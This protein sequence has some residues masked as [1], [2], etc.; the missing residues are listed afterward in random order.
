MQVDRVLVSI[1]RCDV[2]PCIHD[3]I[4]NRTNSIEDPRCITTGVEHLNVST[5]VVIRLK[6]VCDRVAHLIV[7]LAL[8][9]DH[10]EV[11]NMFEYS[12][13]SPWPTIYASL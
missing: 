4:T 12:Y 10:G 5:E 9:K 1:R 3:T 13:G 7:F 11:I 8:H 6:I 2:T